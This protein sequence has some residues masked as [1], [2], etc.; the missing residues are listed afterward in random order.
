MTLLINVLG[1]IWRSITLQK[2]K[3][4]Q[5]LYEGIVDKK[6]ILVDT[7]DKAKIEIQKDHKN[8]QN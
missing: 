5:D 8:V 2:K 3:K 6:F 1:G 4:N 7:L